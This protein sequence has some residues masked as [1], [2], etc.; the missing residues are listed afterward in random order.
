MRSRFGICNFIK[1]N[2][3][4]VQHVSDFMTSYRAENKTMGVCFTYVNLVSI[5]FFYGLALLQRK[6]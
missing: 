5:T 4:T 6:T 1:K 3:A 2:Y